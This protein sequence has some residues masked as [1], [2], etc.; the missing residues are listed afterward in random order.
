MSNVKRHSRGKV[1]DW[2]DCPDNSLLNFPSSFNN[3]LNKVPSPVLSLMES[4]LG[5]KDKYNLRLTC[6]LLYTILPQWELPLYRSHFMPTK[7][8][9]SS[10]ISSVGEVFP[11]PLFP[12]RFG[13]GKLVEKGAILRSSHSYARACMGCNHHLPHTAITL[14]ALIHHGKDAPVL[15]MQRDHHCFHDIPVTYDSKEKQEAVFPQDSVFAVNL[16]QFN[17]PTEYNSTVF[18][19]CSHRC[20]RHLAIQMCGS[21]SPVAVIGQEIVFMQKLDEERLGMEMKYST[22]F[23]KHLSLLVEYSSTNMVVRSFRFR[24]ENFHY[25]APGGGAYTSLDFAAFAEVRPADALGGSRLWLEQCDVFTTTSTQMVM[26]KKMLQ[27]EARAQQSRWFPERSFSAQEY[28][29]YVSRFPFALSAQPHLY[30]EEGE[31]GGDLLLMEMQYSFSAIIYNDG[32]DWCMEAFVHNFEFTREQNRALLKN[33]RNN[34][35]AHYEQ[36]PL[37]KGMVGVHGTYERLRFD[38][39]ILSCDESSIVSE[40]SYEYEDLINEEESESESEVDETDHETDDD[41]EDDDEVMTE[42]A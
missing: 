34:L 42:A 25:R 15:N 20:F 16:L 39:F 6:K 28:S 30:L 35:Q 33:L 31:Q 9:Q 1:A 5:S 17:A 4:Y 22:F 3:M 38:F 36:T 12:E 18:L 26:L 41:D 13:T 24:M 21:P 29:D 10:F 23:S 37:Q 8:L 32:I 14:P 2:S 19:C 7:T 11:S 40:S 27:T